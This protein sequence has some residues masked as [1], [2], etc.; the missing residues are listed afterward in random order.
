ML[1]RVVLKMKYKAPH[2]VPRLQSRSRQLLL[3]MVFEH[4]N[5]SIMCDLRKT[6][7]HIIDWESEF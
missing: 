1:W 4:L 5:N 6:Y 2:L 3:T 7:K